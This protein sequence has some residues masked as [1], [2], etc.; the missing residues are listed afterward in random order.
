[1]TST[2]ARSTRIRSGSVSV[3]L[4]FNEPGTDIPT[5]EVEY[6]VYPEVEGGGRFDEVH[7]INVVDRKPYVLAEARQRAVLKRIE[8]EQPEVWKDLRV[9]ACE[10]RAEENA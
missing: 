3:Y 1:M 5:A 10:N 4:T 6:I 7:V 8:R 2:P 9:R